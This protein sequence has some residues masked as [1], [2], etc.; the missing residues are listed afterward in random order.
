MTV[1]GLK[2]ALF[3]ATES[4]RPAGGDSGVALRDVGDRNP[5]YDGAWWPRSRDL[6][7]ELARLLAAL[8]VAGRGVTRVSF[9]TR[10]WDPAPRRMTFRHRMV[11]LTGFTWIDDRLVTLSG[12]AGQDRLSLMVVPSATEAGERLDGAPPYERVPADEA[13]RRWE[14]EG[15]HVRV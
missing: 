5:R 1:D 10:A 3:Q 11:R 14:N 2:Q 8:D 13:D 4:L 12:S 7:D 9:A 15:G 6:T